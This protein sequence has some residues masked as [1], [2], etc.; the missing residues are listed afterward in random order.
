M[1][2]LGIR[3]RLP[4]LGQLVK[5][6]MEQ[7]IEVDSPLFKLHHKASSVLIML[8]FLFVAVE[9]YLD[10]KAIVCHNEMKPYPK[11]YCWIH[12][13]SY[14]EQN[15]RR[16]ITIMLFVLNNESFFNILENKSN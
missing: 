16:K 13:Y 3:D 9:N 5:W 14:I 4:L 7:G 15:F 2:P 1:A 6:F 12:G 8:G 11:L 10:T